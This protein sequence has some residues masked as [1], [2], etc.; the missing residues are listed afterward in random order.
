MSRLAP[1][2]P[3]TAEGQTAEIF[4]KLKKQIGAVPNIFRSLAVHPQALGAYL[5]IESGATTLSGA[6][7][8]AIALATGEINGCEYCLAAHTLIGKGFGLSLEE[9]K[10]IRQGGATDPKRNA[11]VRLVNEIVENRGRVSQGAY[12]AFLDAGYTAAQIPEV[13]LVV[14]QNLFTNYFNNLNGTEVDFPAAPSLEPV[15]A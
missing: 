12:Q 3:E 5:N 1:I 6:D 8:Q 11:L 14:T 4:A 9:T 10:K 15:L 13:L 2:A 7:K